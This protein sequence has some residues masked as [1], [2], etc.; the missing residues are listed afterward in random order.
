LS[1]PTWVE[2]NPAEVFVSALRYN[3]HV[4]QLR[5]I[6]KDHAANTRYCIRL[7][8]LERWHTLIIALPVHSLL[9]LHVLDSWSSHVMVSPKYVH[10]FQPE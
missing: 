4:F 7:T 6:N 10:M 3:K 8:V 5:W 1:T 9:N 2:W